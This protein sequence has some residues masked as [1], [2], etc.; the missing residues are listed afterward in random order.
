MF[1]IKNYTYNKYLD[2]LCSVLDSHCHIGLVKNSSNYAKCLT[3]FRA[4][5]YGVIPSKFEFEKTLKNE[6]IYV[7]I[8]F[9]PLEVIKYSD[10]SK[11]LEFFKNNIENTQFIGEIGLDFSKNN[12]KHKD[13]QIYVF[14]EICKCLSKWK[15]KIISIHS[16]NASKYILDILTSTKADKN[17]TIIFHWFSDSCK[18]LN[19]AK[20]RGYLFSVG[21]R[22]VQS[23]RG[24]EY[25]RQIPESKLL[26]E[27]DL[28]WDNQ[29]LTCENHFNI[30][31]DFLLYLREIRQV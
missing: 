14:K 11:E 28:P 19:D 1:N 18:Y 23:R 5:S 10:T 15:N 16:V 17:N 2:G 3:K 31:N 27:T 26:I 29:D 20:D 30:L 8:G 4:I 21:P 24:F 7:G 22:M 13:I 25:A 6:N 9:H 12:E